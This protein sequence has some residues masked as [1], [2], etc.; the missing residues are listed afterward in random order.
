MRCLVKLL[1]AGAIVA[2][3][4]SSGAALAQSQAQSPTL[5]AVKKRA[6]ELPRDR[7]STSTVVSDTD[8]YFDSAAHRLSEAIASFIAR[9]LRGE[10]R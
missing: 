4:G 5:E 3:I 8:H 1:A 10:C 2:G 6:A 7:C 9:A